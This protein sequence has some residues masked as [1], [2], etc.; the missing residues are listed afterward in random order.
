M[1][2]LI[3]AWHLL[4]P[5]S[6]SWR[7]ARTVI[8]GGLRNPEMAD[9]V[10]RRANENGAVCAVTYPLPKEEL[11]QH[12]MWLSFFILLPWHLKTQSIATE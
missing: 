12:G 7:V 2:L 5:L 8:F 9:D 10:H 1:H 3:I 6:D 4:Y 11:G